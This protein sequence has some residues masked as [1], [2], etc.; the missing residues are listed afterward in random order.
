[1]KALALTERGNPFE[2]IEV[3]EPE[4]RNE[5]ELKIKIYG[6]GICG[7]ELHEYQD[8]PKEKIDLPKILGHEYSGTIVDKG[9]RVKGLEIGDRVI[10]ESSAGC[11][12][13]IYCRSGYTNLCPSREGISGSFTDYIVVP[14]RYVY[15]LPDNISLDLALLSEPLACVI[16]GLE[17]TKIKQGDLVVVIGPGPLGILA[18][19]LAV[20]SGTKVVLIG[21]SSSENRLKIAAEL[22]IPHII[23][24][25]NTNAKKYIKK[26]D[27]FGA[28]VV[29]SCVGSAEV[30]NLGFELLKNGGSYTEL[31]LF[32][33]NQ[34]SVDFEKIVSKEI[35]VVG[36][37]SHKPESWNQLLKLYESGLLD[38][39][40]K[41]ITGE[42]QLSEWKK[43]FENLI[44]RKDTKAVIYSRVY[45]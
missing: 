1:M 35:N 16:N 30:V 10:A 21:R 38:G 24:S 33:R 37:V 29:I 43:A 18:A 22:S 14:S 19:Y 12:K 23:N 34:V 45:V 31:G 25:D 5:D 3:D 17:K 15:K 40:Q 39:L 13:C 11:E 27:S 44:S 7:S 41:I 42:Y 2:I 28:D 9:S 36:A 6:S 4:I 32:N 8:P 26:L 20:K